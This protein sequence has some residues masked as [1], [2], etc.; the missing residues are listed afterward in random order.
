MPF[1]RKIFRSRQRLFS[2]FFFPSSKS[3]FINQCQREGSRRVCKKKLNDQGHE[4]LSKGRSRRENEPDS[5][6]VFGLRP[7]WPDRRVWYYTAI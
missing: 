1:R 6:L 5:D 2:A 4:G 3:Q 7:V